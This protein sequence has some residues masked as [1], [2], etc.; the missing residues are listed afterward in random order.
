MVWGQRSRNAQNFVGRL[1]N[2]RHIT[3]NYVYNWSGSLPSGHPL[4]SIVNSMYNHIAMAY[5]W[6]DIQPKTGCIPDFYDHVY[7]CVMGDD[8]VFSVSSRDFNFNEYTISKSMR[9]LGLNYT[10]DLKT[11]IEDKGLRTL[12]DI[13]FLKRKFD[14]DSDMRVQR[15]GLYWKAPKA[16]NFVETVMWFTKNKS[17][18]ERQLLATNVD[19]V[20]AEMALCSKEMFENE[21]V[22]LMKLYNEAALQ[23]GGEIIR[24]RN[25][26]YLKAR[27]H[28]LSY[29]GYF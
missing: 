7:L 6:Y 27:Q 24:L 5:C 17:V 18:T 3:D 19:M 11:E 23:F 4:T 13:S 29:E 2:S 10:T 22:Y 15:Q 26:S 21:G 20:L 12:Y 28:L 1:V 14:F 9:K 8:N 16:D 25:T